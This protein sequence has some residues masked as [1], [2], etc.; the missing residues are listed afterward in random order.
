MVGERRKLG[1]LG[2]PRGLWELLGICKLWKLG[3]VG[4]LCKLGILV[5]IGWR[6]E[7]SEIGQLWGIWKLWKVVL[8]VYLCL[9][10]ERISH[11]L[12]ECG[13]P[14]GVAKMAI[15]RGILFA[16]RVFKRDMVD[17]V[18]WAARPMIFARLRTTPH[19]C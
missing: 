7:I 14:D 13:A 8:L 9:I 2:K 15:C 1:E 16:I 18:E 3:E 12:A 19:P 6:V 10:A 5:E 4:K 17:F 11:F